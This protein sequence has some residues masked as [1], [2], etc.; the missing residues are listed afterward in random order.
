M[1]VEQED[2]G[3]GAS[4]ARCGAWR[5]GSKVPNL[6]KRT[7]G[8]VVVAPEHAGARQLRRLL[9]AVMTVGSDLDLPLVL[10]RIA[11]S[12]RELV[13][14]KYCA[15]GVLD[16]SRTRLSQFIT[17][18]IDEEQR[19]RIGNLPEG[20]GILGLLILEPK[21]LRLPDL[22]EHPDSYGFP[23]NHPPMTTFL[24]VPLFVRGEVFGNLYLTE[25][26]DGEVFNDVD[27]EL[28]MGL[29]AAAGVA[30]ENA[31]LHEQFREMTLLEDRERIAR[32]LHDTVIQ[33][34][35]ATGLALQGTARLS[36]R[37][38]VKARI[39]EAVDDLDVT[40]RQIRSA[41]F[42]LDTRRMPGRSVRREILDLV[43]DSVR[44]LGFEPVVRFEG[45]IDAAVSDDVADHL[46][47]TL[48][49]ALSNVAKHAHATRA[50]VLIHVDGDLELRV[51]DDGRGGVVGPTAVGHGM[52]NMGQRA[53][54]LGG[55]LEVGAAPAGSGTLLSWCVPLQ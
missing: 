35:F 32:D 4:L 13:R 22:R 43:A 8:S 42:E 55:R 12:A 17:V 33:R 46:M 49:E 14:A 44:A 5:A 38:D 26:E 20:H 29:A 15:L 53:Q 10:E 52:R 50:E 47:A 18:G 19:Q 21:P 45:P 27:E 37:D 30:I 48:R 7:L 25:K 40:V 16:P 9:D 24:G 3:H 51:V 28:A 23:P 2:S 6:K 31:R 1:V 39:Q 36:Q 34:L 11:E 54:R 41:I